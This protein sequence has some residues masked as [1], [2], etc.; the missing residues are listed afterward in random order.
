MHTYPIL[1]PWRLTLSQPAV[2]RQALES[3]VDVRVHEDERSR[4][5][6]IDARYTYAELSRACPA[7]RDHIDLMSG[8]SQSIG[9]RSENLHRLQALCFPLFEAVHM[10][11]MSLV[12]LFNAGS[13]GCMPVR[14]RPTSR[15]IKTA[16]LPSTP[17]FLSSSL[18][19]LAPTSLS[20]TILIDLCFLN[21]SANLLTF[22]APMISHVI[23]KSS[24]PFAHITSASD[25]LAT[26]PP[27]APASTSLWANSADLVVFRCG[28]MFTPV[29]RRRSMSFLIFASIKSRSTIMDGVSNESSE[30]PTLGA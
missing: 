15:S 3:S 24:K 19:A 6:F 2:R 5:D 10:L 11:E 20:T 9:S 4:L 25:S 7:C 21:N 26:H 8:L 17:L 29:G 14:C 22:G 16:I 13:P 30:S 28:R 23:N 27:F 18:I 12:A 1:I